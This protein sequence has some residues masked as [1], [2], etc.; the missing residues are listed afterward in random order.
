MKRSRNTWQRL[1]LS[2]HRLPLSV[3]VWPVSTAISLQAGFTNI[4]YERDESLGVKSSRL[5]LNL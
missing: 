4:A 3:L 2:S 1:D 5:R